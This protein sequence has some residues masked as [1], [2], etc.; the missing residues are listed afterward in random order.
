MTSKSI[1]TTLLVAGLAV[2]GST[3]LARGEGDGSR[4][5]MNF[6]ALDADGNGEVTREEMRAAREGRF[7]EAD[8]DGDGRLSRDEMIAAAQERAAKRVDQMIKRF[9]ADGDGAVSAAELPQ[10]DEKR[11]ARMFDKIDADN[12][13]GISAEE[14]AEARE[15]RRGHGKRHHKR[16]P[17]DAGEDSAPKAD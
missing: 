1:I 14:F 2:T 17:G 5:G 3:A 11:A 7:M 8:A 10:P 15:M 16:G 6:E 12:S 9:D 4:H 13:G